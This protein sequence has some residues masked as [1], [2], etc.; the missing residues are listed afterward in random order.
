[1]RNIPHISTEN[2]LFLPA[3]VG[4]LTVHAVESRH[5]GK[6]LL[7]FSQEHPREGALYF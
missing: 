3:Y 2:A 1:M 7:S 5:R 4:Q 6:T